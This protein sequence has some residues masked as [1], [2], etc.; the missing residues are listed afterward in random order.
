MPCVLDAFTSSPGE[1]DDLVKV[2]GK[3]ERGM[4]MAG[5]C[6]DVVCVGCI[7]HASHMFVT[8]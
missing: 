4:H 8:V 6:M 5:C 3:E 2:R 1:G 7:M